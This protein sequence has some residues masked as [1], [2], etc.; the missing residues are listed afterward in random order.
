MA[1]KKIRVLVADDEP[2]VVEIM[3]KRLAIAG[4]DVITALDGREAWKLIVERL[5]DVIVLDINMPGMDGLSILR[6]MRSAPPTSKWQAVIIVSARNQVENMH[7]GVDLQADH[8]LT[9][10]CSPEDVVSA[11]RL[12][13]KVGPLKIQW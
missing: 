2:D 7:E 12:V 6:A 3:E 5:P 1:E 13:M 10:P 11:V 8:Y 4:F 9:K